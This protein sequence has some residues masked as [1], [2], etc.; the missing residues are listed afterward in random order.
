M[1]V[2]WVRIYT[3]KENHGWD[4]SDNTILDVD[5]D[6][7]AGIFFMSRGGGVQFL[8]TVEKK[9]NS[10]KHCEIQTLAV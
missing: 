2:W 6:K 5:F 10:S 7:Q 9:N 3:A 1:L 4:K 8:I